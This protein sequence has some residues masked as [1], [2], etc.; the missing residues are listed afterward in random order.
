[1]SFWRF[2][3]TRNA[4]FPANFAPGSAQLHATKR[5]TVCAAALELKD[6]SV[7]QGVFRSFCEFN[8]TTG[9]IHYTH[10]F[11]FEVPQSLENATA[12]VVEGIRIP[13]D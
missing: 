13:L 7:Y 2:G 12:L 4:L 5:S 11:V 9:E 8:E 10:G 6:G 1:M 3:N